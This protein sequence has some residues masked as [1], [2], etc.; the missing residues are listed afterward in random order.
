MKLCEINQE[1]VV[2]IHNDFNFSFSLSILNC[3]SFAI[4]N[5]QEHIKNAL[6]HA[7]HIV[8]ERSFRKKCEKFIERD[9]DKI[10]D[11]IIKGEASK[12]ICSAIGFCV[13]EKQELNEI[14]M[15]FFWKF[16]HN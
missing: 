8:H 1:Y 2:Y 15:Y 13:A 12:L 5:L 10:I 6:N 14:R 3:L 9:G 16:I 7:C 4:F 11:L